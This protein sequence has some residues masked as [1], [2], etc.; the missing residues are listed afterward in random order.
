MVCGGTYTPCYPKNLSAMINKVQRV[1]RPFSTSQFYHVPWFLNC[2]TEPVNSSLKYEWQNWCSGAFLTANQRRWMNA[3]EC[4]VGPELTL[5]KFTWNWIQSLDVDGPEVDRM[6]TPLWHVL[7]HKCH[8]KLFSSLPCLRF[9]V[10]EMGYCVMVISSSQCLRDYGGRDHL[11]NRRN[12][13][14]I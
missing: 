12:G 6:K 13:T 11:S 14:D 7:W 4:S 3:T 5:E 1:T 10:Y 2:G 9:L 8:K